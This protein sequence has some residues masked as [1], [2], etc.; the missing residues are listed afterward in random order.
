MKTLYIDIY[1]LINFTVDL[2][3]LY[4]SASLSKISTTQGRLLLSSLLGG[5][6]AVISVLFIDRSW[7]SIILSPIFIVMMVVII[8]PGVGFY[9]RIK[10]S[11]SFVLMQIIIGGLVY[12]SYCTLDRLL[13]DYD[14]SGVGGINKKLLI[15][16]VFVL[17]SIGALKIL[18][19]FFTKVKSEKC[20]EVEVRCSGR[21]TRITALVDSG[22]MVTDPFDKSP[23]M[24][25]NSSIAERMFSVGYNSLF[26]IDKL[27]YEIKKRLRPISVHSI[28]GDSIIYAIKPDEA[29]IIYKD[30]K[31]RI[32]LSIAIGKENSFSGYSALIPLSAVE[33]IL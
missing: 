15:L 7:V 5:L 25:V 1:F 3:T 30:K 11:V 12:Y 19:S 29:Y 21:S 6:Y 2:L 17:L 18:L 8:S 14:I 32:R 23:V 31:E 28:G 16:S 22:N 4:F 27:G 20:A 26:E 24:F 33:D 13:A 9:R 10:Y